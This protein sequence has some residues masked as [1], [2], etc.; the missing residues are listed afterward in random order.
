MNLNALRNESICFKMLDWSGFSTRIR[1]LWVIWS[2]FMLGYIDVCVY[3]C[4]CVGGGGVKM[5]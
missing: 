2:I 4:M 5:E 1:C 3:M